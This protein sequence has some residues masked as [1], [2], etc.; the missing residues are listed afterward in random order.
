MPEAPLNEEIH[1]NPLA[2]MAGIPPQTRLYAFSQLAEWCSG[3]MMLV[4]AQNAVPFDMSDR[5]VRA[6]DYVPVLRN[7]IMMDETAAVML[8]AMLSDAQSVGHTE[9][10]VT[11]G[12]RTYARQLELY[13]SMEDK[14][15]VALPNHSEHQTGFAVDISYSGV[16]IGNSVQGTW[17]TENAYLYGF[18]LRYPADK[19]DITGIPYEPW[20]FRYVGQPHA[21]IMHERNMVLEEYIDYLREQK[22]ISRE[23]NG[24]V[25]RV[26]YFL[27][28][29]ELIEI[30]DEYTFKA[31]VD[32]TG[33]V[34]LTKWR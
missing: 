13:E 25:Y 8:Q 29:D 27:D 20:H 28:G 5:Q 2:L 17:L 24:V 4:N 33:G 16:N 32:N 7:S 30:L 1:N 12:F 14:S 19:T 9:F 18:V 15:L 34:V 6:G 11:E 31:S 23:L 21:F 22:E 10:Y 26:I 3:H